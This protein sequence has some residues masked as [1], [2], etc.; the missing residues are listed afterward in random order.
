MTRAVVMVVCAAV[1]LF[2][3]F[4]PSFLPRTLHLVAAI[5]RRTVTVCRGFSKHMGPGVYAAACMGRM[6]TSNTMAEGYRPVAVADTGH[7]GEHCVLTQT[8]L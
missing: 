7:A 6:G 3:L 4:G 2:A 1:L 8:D 5:V